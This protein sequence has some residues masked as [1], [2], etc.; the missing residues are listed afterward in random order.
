MPR[1][2]IN[3]L[4]TRLSLLYAG[5]FAA[6][7]LGVSVLLFAMVERIA[8]Y[9][10]EQQ[11]VASGAVYDR[12]WQQRSEQMQDAAE[13]LSSGFRLSCSRRHRRPGH[14]NLSAR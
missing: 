1:F 13:L 3:T 8:R 12:L 2:R 14:R 6:V 10:V 7:M 9:E 11:L 5:L 4:S